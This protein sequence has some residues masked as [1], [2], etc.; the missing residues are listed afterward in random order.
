[1]F[2]SI[3]NPG[4]TV[5]PNKFQPGDKAKCCRFVHFCDET[6]H[7][8]GKVYSVTQYNVSYYNVFHNYYEK[9]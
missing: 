4:S 1:M 8:V 7:L 9:L 2:I 6:E 3:N 5:Y